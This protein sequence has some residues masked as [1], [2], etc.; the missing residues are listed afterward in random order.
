MSSNIVKKD[1][2]LIVVGR[3]IDDKGKIDVSTLSEDVV[4]RCREIT[5]GVKDSETLKVFGAD[6]MNAG[7]GCGTKLLE[8]NKIDKA[9]EVGQHVK[10]L[11]D[12]I[13]ETELQ[14]PSNLKGWRKFVAMIPFVGTPAVQSAEKIIA[15]YE[16]SKGTVDKI[17]ESVKDMQVD[18]DQDKNVLA[19]MEDKTIELV[20]YLSA[21]VVALA[22]LYRDETEKLQEMIK[23]RNEDPSLVTA[24][25]ISKQKEFVEKIDRRSFD[26]FMAGQKSRNLDLPEIKMMRQNVERLQENAEEIWRTIIPNW[27]NSIA[28][29][30]MNQKQKKTLETQQMIK[31]VNNNITLSNAKMLKETTAGIL[32]ESSR[33]VLDVD[34]YNEAFTTVLGTLD[35]TFD[36]L[37]TIK[38][39]RDQARAKIMEINKKAAA[40]FLE[41][42]QKA[43]DFYADDTKFIPEALK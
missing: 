1:Q 20:E 4:E 22:V 9:G 17:V 27:E 41:I 26:L 33:S 21:H 34:T 40:K 19:V 39:E 35:E 24:E 15:R 6:V 36:K 18:L 5:R 14:D 31:D 32:V 23:K 43:E 16:S 11:V 30:I 8:M 2:S 10:D 12:A 29:A 37:A 3:T 28:L 42:Q 13:R 7:S 25:E 38:E